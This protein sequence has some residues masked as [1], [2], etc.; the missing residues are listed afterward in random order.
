MSGRAGIL[1]AIFYSRDMNSDIS[2]ARCSPDVS[3]TPRPY[4]EINP[5]AG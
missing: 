3:I 5:E 2:P 4:A 1:T